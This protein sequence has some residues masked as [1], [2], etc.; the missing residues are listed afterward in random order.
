MDVNLVELVGQKTNDL[1]LL[2]RN[3]LSDAAALEDA[4]GLLSRFE[5]T[6]DLIKVLEHATNES[7]IYIITHAL[8]G[9]C[10]SVMVGG[11]LADGQVDQ[12]ELA[13][14]YS[15]AKPCADFL[16]SVLKQYE[17]FNGLGVERVSDFL[18]FFLADKSP[19]GG[20]CTGSWLSGLRLCTIL[21]ILYQEAS[22]LDNY[23]EI[24]TTLLVETVRIGGIDKQER[25]TL[26]QQHEII[27]HH[28]SIVAEVTDHGQRP[29]P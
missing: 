12:E 7:L 11:I 2:L 29:W 19:L 6:E 27:S 22:A 3:G 4:I 9:D 13:A 26:K 8:I 20:G 21:D 18:N 14:A 1:A 24:I 23:E 17:R 28:R 15:L 5:G 25:Q 10:L 16:A